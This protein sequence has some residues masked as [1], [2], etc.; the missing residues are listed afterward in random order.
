MSVANPLHPGY[1]FIQK[2]LGTQFTATGQVIMPPGASLAWQIAPPTGKIWI[3]GI[4]IFGNPRDA[5]TNT[6]LITP[7]FY[8]YARHSMI[9]GFNV[10]QA[11]ESVSKST[12]PVEI[13][14]QV[15][16]P[17]VLTTVN[18]TAL[19]IYQDITFALIEIAEENYKKFQRLWEGLYNFELLLGGLK[20]T[21][22]DSLVFLLKSLQPV[23]PLPVPSPTLEVTTH[24]TLHE[25]V[26]RAIK[27][28][29]IP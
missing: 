23:V 29:E 27:R 3:V 14:L 25:D 16:D 22:V 5:A 7:N 21:D 15:G 4:W 2:R 10:G 11:M 6:I 28:I 26:G 19:T 1:L 17:L 20:D 24:P 13:D 9:R 12:F 18:N 8:T